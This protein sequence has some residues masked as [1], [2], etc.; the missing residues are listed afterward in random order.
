MERTLGGRGGGHALMRAGP[1]EERPGVSPR[2]WAGTKRRRAEARRDCPPDSPLR[3]SR[4]PGDF[5]SRCQGYRHVKPVVDAAVPFRPTLQ[6]VSQRRIQVSTGVNLPRRSTPNIDFSLSRPSFDVKTS[7]RKSPAIHRKARQ[8]SRPAKLPLF[9]LSQTPNS[10]PRAGG[11]RHSQ[12]PGISN[13][14]HRRAA[15]YRGGERRTTW[16]SVELRPE[17]RDAG[18]GTGGIGRGAGPGQE[19]RGIRGFLPGYARDF[20]CRHWTW[21][22]RR[23]LR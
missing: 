6:I 22:T 3:P 19:S 21:H 20:G 9:R 16:P 17:R 23:K 8:T 7:R 18:H 1:F 15:L 2:R 11:L 14:D 4:I 13:P 5:G 12:H 10:S